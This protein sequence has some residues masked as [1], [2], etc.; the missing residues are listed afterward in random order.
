METVVFNFHDEDN[1]IFNNF[2]L[3]AGD[4]A[5]SVTWKDIDQSISLYANHKIFIEKIA[6]LHNAHW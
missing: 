1:S 2:E 3:Q 5:G 4:D 6:K